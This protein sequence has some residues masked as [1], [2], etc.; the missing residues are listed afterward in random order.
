MLAHDGESSN[1][2]DV[3]EQARKEDD[4]NPLREALEIPE[5]EFNWPVF[6]PADSDPNIH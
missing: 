2:R 6:D 5:E 4:R 3:P 1:Q